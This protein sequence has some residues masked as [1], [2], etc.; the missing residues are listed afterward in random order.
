[1]NPGFETFNSAYDLAFDVK[2]IKSKTYTVLPTQTSLYAQIY[3][4]PED[5]VISPGN[6]IPEPTPYPHLIHE[7]HMIRNVIDIPRFKAAVTSAIEDVSLLRSR[8]YRNDR[9]IDAD[10]EGFMEKARLVDVDALIQELAGVIESVA[11]V[12]ASVE[13]YLGEAKNRHVNPVIKYLWA[14]GTGEANNKT[15]FV[16]VASAASMDHY[17]LSAVS[18]IIIE[19]YEEYCL[20]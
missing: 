6:H 18:R 16:F 4:H 1:M 3:P 8:I 19:K 14:S 2:N 7:M 9:I 10:V 12:S 20:M 13:R 17:S 11:D 15:Y 5:A